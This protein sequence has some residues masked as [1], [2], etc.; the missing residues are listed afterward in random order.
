MYTQHRLGTRL[1][2]H[3]RRP[4]ARPIWRSNIN[5]RSVTKYL[6]YFCKQTKY[7]Y[8]WA[9]RIWNYSSFFVCIVFLNSL[10]QYILQFMSNNNNN[11]LS[12][13]K[14]VI[15]VQYMC[16]ALR[17]CLPVLK[18]VRH[19]VSSADLMKSFYNEVIKQFKEVCV[20]FI[21]QQ[22][23]TVVYHSCL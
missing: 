21:K 15:F 6:K 1:G 23:S 17:D 13:N 14:C 22:V 20:G 5:L 11:S 8:E 9:C 18:Q 16:C 10:N 19:L 2:G 4:S 3:L 12:F 7:F